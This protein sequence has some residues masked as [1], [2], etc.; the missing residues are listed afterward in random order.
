MER[1]L[2]A[3][4]KF[5]FTVPSDVLVL[6]EKLLGDTRRRSDSVGTNKLSSLVLEI[7]DIEMFPDRSIFIVPDYR[8][9]FRVKWDHNRKNPKRI[10][11][12]VQSIK[13]LNCKSYSFS[14]L[15]SAF[16][17]QNRKYG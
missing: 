8:L 13:P 10:E 9:S 14:D 1:R 11:A 12:T 17:E 16:L 6:R 5:L 7:F 15:A 2:A 3:R 4:A